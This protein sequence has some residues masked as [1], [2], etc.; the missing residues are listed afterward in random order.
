MRW[1]S[2]IAT[3]SLM[4]RISVHD[5]W[6]GES[7]NKTKQTNKQTKNPR[8]NVCTCVPEAGMN[9]RESKYIPQYLWLVII[10]PYL[11]TCSWHTSHFPMNIFMM[12]WTNTCARIDWLNWVITIKLYRLLSNHHVDQKRPLLYWDHI[13]NRVCFGPPYLSTIAEIQEFHNEIIYYKKSWFGVPNCIAHFID[14][15]PFGN[16]CGSLIFRWLKNVKNCQ[17]SFYSP[18]SL[19]RK[20]AFKPLPHELTFV[21]NERSLVD[22]RLKGIVPWAPILLFVVSREKNKLSICWWLPCRSLGVTESPICMCIAHKTTRLR[23]ERLI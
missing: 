19:M 21:C 5:K 18:F 8:T 3:Q 12:F 23:N 1:I 17:M 16:A 20:D 10:C 2:C 14:R 22:S 4:I 13:E 9:G 15:Q 7:K 6:L 11:D